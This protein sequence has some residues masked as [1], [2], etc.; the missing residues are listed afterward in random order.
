MLFTTL[1]LCTFTD[2]NLAD[3]RMLPAVNNG[4]LA[5][6]GYYIPVFTAQKHPELSTLYGLSGNKNRENLASK[7]KTPI[8]WTDYCQTVNCTTG[9][10]GIS[11]RPPRDDIEGNQYFVENAYKGHFID[12]PESDCNLYP[13]NC[14]GHV[15]HPGCAWGTFGESQMYWNNIPLVSRGRKDNNTG[16]SYSH[17]QQIWLAANAT[18]NNVLLWWWY[19]DPMLMRFEKSDFRLHRVDLKRT[20]RKCM[21]WRETNIEVC[22]SDVNARI[23]ADPLGSCDYPVERLAKVF[24]R[25]LKTMQDNAHETKRSPAFPFMS[26]VKVEPYAMDDL[27]REWLKI[28]IDFMG[29]DSRHATCKWIYDNIES[30]E[31][32]IPKNY[33]KEVSDATNPL[34]IV[35][36]SLASVAIL[37]VLA[38]GV[39]IFMMRHREAIKHAQVKVLMWIVLGKISGSCTKYLRVLY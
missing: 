18:R 19:P 33:P 7:F 22:S 4:M 34:S 12:P 10:D 3:G 37:L 11:S 31:K 9:D 35:A 14:T 21:T 29:I 8:T 5:R 17:M 36:Y 39:F 23:G 32:F 38:A 27:F 20:S 13:D 26:N 6:V 30:F 1:L 25:S 24:S 28:N 2:I 16:Y 15:V